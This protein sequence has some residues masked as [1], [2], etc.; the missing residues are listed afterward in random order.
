L[1]G[2]CLTLRKDRLELF[3]EEA[4]AVTAFF[5]IE[6][7]AYDATEGSVFVGVDDVHLEIHVLTVNG[8]LGGSVE[9]ELSSDELGHVSILIGLFETIRHTCKAN[10]DGV[11]LD[12]ASGG[13]T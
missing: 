11:F 7:N 8:V 10:Y 13:C 1:C 9:V 12:F 5:S 6:E 3:D 4:L 2:I